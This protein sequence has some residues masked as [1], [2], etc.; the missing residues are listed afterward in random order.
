MNASLPAEI[1]RKVVE[2]TKEL[3]NETNL[4]ITKD[5]ISIQAMDSSHVS[6]V[7]IVFHKDKF[8][9]YSCTKELQVG[10]SM[11]TLSKIMKL[12]N[13][14]DVITLSLQNTDKLKI[15]LTNSVNSTQS[16]KVNFEQNLL[17]LEQETFDLPDFDYD[18]KLELNSKEFAR[19]MNDLYTLGDTVE[20]S[21]TSN[22][23]TF[24]VTG[25]SGKGDIQIPNSCE[26]N[27]TL[28]NFALRY[29]CLFA[30]ANPI[31]E[32]INIGISNQS[33][34]MFH[35]ETGMGDLK[36]YLAPKLDD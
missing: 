14:T 19:M 18:L 26:T 24:A 21:N 33:P 27:R 8:L 17:Q 15:E 4:F 36:F 16:R 7:S 2:S 5:G 9:T 3:V 35:F 12:S 13:P 10:V 34:A 6:L 30:K 31:A 20:I 23:V 11:V 1:F 22:L 32:K 28:A 25:E 29:V